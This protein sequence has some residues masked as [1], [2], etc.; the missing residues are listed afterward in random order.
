MGRN[1]ERAGALVSY[2]GSTSRSRAIPIPPGASWFRA[3]ALSR[4]HRPTRVP[5]EATE[6]SA[7]RVSGAPVVQV[8]SVEDLREVPVCDV[9]VGCGGVD[10][11]HEAV[12]RGLKWDFVVPYPRT[13]PCAPPSRPS[14]GLRDA[15]IAQFLESIL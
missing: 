11:D 9:Q 4:V 13:P 10:L 15:S 5:S 2:S 8:Q 14:I 3:P 7:E 12:G 1:R 6:C